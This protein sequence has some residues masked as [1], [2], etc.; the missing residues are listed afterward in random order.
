MKEQERVA[1]TIMAQIK[2]Q[3]AAAFKKWEAYNFVPQG[4]GKDWFGNT[5][6]GA[7]GFQVKGSKLPRGK[8]H[9]QLDWMDTYRIMFIDQDPEKLLASQDGMPP[10]EVIEGI[11]FDQLVEVINERV[12]SLPNR[13]SQKILIDITEVDWTALDA[14]KVSEMMQFGPG[15]NKNGIRHKGGLSFCLEGGF[16][17]IVTLTEQD[18]YNL[19]LFM[20]E[21]DENGESVIL[22]EHINLD[23]HGVVREIDRITT[24]NH[25]ASIKRMIDQLKT[26]VSKDADRTT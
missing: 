23:P 9:I 10:C 6:R 18:H 8:V 25:M 1:M 20:K 12:C 13:M 16:V 7:L 22:A 11:Y 5:F 2:A 26:E 24:G 4:E 17:A 15:K 3:D 19:A 14:W 21:T